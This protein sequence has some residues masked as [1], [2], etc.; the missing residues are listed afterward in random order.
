MKKRLRHAEVFKEG[1]KAF[2][3][4]PPDYAKAKDCF[5]QVASLAPNWAEGHHYLASALE[6][7]GEKGMAAKAYKKAIECDCKDPRPRIALGHLL[8]SMG[9]LKGAIDELQL[10][11]TLKP[12]YGEADA[13]LLLAE[14]FEKSK[15][16]SKA[17]DQWKIVEQ[18][19][20]FYP[21][22]DK[23]MRE[24][25]RKLRDYAKHQQ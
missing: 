7:L 25:Q 8:A 23:P 20:P 18:M 5:D 19:E 11:L 21:S 3:S 24:A 10:G 12:H 1:Q 4:E 13:R 9:Q 22:H 15:E 16:L 6:R 14:A 17:V 2:F